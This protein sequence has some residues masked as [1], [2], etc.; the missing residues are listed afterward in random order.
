VSPFDVLALRGGQLGAIGGPARDGLALAG[1]V[2][3]HPAAGGR[4][5][6]L[7]EQQTTLSI[8]HRQASAPAEGLAPLGAHLR[9]R[10]MRKGVLCAVAAAHVVVLAPASAVGVGRAAKTGVLAPVPAQLDGV[11]V[12]AWLVREVHG[13]ASHANVDVGRGELD[14][15]A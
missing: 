12:A 3:D 7:V 2:L 13:R 5:A 9:R 6:V 1:Q 11:D 14:D 8:E 15:V 4:L 10:A